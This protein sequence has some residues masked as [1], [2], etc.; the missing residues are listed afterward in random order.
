[1]AD[2]AVSKTV[3]ETRESSNLSSGTTE[4]E[5]EVVLRTTFL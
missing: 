1:M 3:V 2:V 5:V 4:A